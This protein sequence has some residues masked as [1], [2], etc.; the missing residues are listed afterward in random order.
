MFQNKVFLAER[1]ALVIDILICD[2][3]ARCSSFHQRE[4]MVKEPG[5]YGVLNQFRSIKLSIGPTTNIWQFYSQH[6]FLV[7]S[8]TVRLSQ[9]TANLFDG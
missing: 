4:K 8:P 6:R 5:I 3:Q 1:L 2:A 7:L 9:P